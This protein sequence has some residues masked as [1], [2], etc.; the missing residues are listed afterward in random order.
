MKKI[1]QYIV[2]ILT[3]GNGCMVAGQKQLSSCYD[4]STYK[5]IDT[6]AVYIISEMMG[7]PYFV[8]S[9]SD[10]V[11]LNTANKGLQF[12]KDGR[13]TAFDRQSPKN[14]LSGV[15]CI[16]NE[17]QEIQFKMK[18][19]Q[20]GKFLSTARLEIRNDTIISDVLPS[21]QT[22]GYRIIYVKSKITHK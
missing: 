2:L 7:K 18:H 3:V 11:M 19:V 20:S 12:Y 6:S 15:Y 17:K 16:N 9:K 1:F 5:L 13:V 14:N 21:P 22:K 8:K 10:T 4:A